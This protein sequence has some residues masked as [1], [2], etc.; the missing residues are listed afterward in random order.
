MATGDALALLLHERLP[1][2]HLRER[3]SDRARMMACDTAGGAISARRSSDA[4]F[5]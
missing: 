4:Q 3:S 1:Q 5:S 2:R